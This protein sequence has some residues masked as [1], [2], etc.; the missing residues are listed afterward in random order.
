MTAHATDAPTYRD[1][2]AE[3]EAEYM[4]EERASVQLAG[5]ALDFSSL[6][7]E[8]WEGSPEPLVIF[9]LM[10]R[11]RLDPG[12]FLAYLHELNIAATVSESRVP[13]SGFLRV[14]ASPIAHDDEGEDEEPSYG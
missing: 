4:P 13:A 5:L 2:L 14:V 10:P 3:Y 8:Y 6:C 9:V 1:D 12:L 7:T 11:A